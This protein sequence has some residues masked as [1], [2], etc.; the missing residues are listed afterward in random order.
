MKTRLPP[1]AQ[2]E[3]L[4]ERVGFFGIL[5][6]A[7]IPNPLFDLAGITCGH[8][9]VP[10]WTFFGATLIGKVSGRPAEV[11]GWDRRGEWDRGML[12]CRWGLGGVVGSSLM[13]VWVVSDWRIVWRWVSVK[14][15]I[16]DFFLSV[17]V[18]Y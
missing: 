13:C 12:G 1:P 5:A 9:L 7:S 6:C 18:T 11:W 16:A 4:V 2:V 8:F 3:R 15:R 17:I 14:F 10:F